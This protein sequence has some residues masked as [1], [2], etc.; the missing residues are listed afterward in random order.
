MLVKGEIKTETKIPC[1]P[2]LF[3]SPLFFPLLLTHLPWAA[4][5]SLLQWGSLQACQGKIPAP[6]PLLPSSLGPSWGP[7]AAVPSL[8]PSFSAAL[9]CSPFRNLFLLAPPARLRGFVCALCGSL[10]LSGTSVS[11][12]QWIFGDLKFFKTP[13][14]ITDDPGINWQEQWSHYHLSWLI[15][16]DVTTGKIFPL[17]TWCYHF[18]TDSISQGAAIL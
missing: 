3:P 9:A 2:R 18:V 5:M 4:G 14:M 10:E 7:C 13:H 16:R 1:L 17:T 12:T 6:G 8:A 11:S 15:Q